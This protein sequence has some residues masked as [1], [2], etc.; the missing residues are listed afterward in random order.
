MLILA[1]YLVIGLILGI[2]SYGEAEDAARAYDAAALKYFGEFAEL[3]F[4]EGESYVH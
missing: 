1:I 2:I 4:K 3:N